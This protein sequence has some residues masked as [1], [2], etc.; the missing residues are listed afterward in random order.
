MLCWLT[1]VNSGG[2]VLHVFLGL[3]FVCCLVLR[4]A[5]CVC[6][7]CVWY[8][9]VGMVL[10]WTLYLLLICLWVFNDWWLLL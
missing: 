5:A 10:L 3:R 8:L 1:S 4:L 9:I 7:A 6:F 2:M